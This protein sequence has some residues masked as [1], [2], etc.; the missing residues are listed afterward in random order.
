MPMRVSLFNANGLVGKANQIYSFFL[1]QDIDLMFIVETWL[2]PSNGPIFLDT[3][4]NITKFN[5]GIIK[6]GKR[7]TGGI[8]GFCKPSLKSFIRIIHEDPDSNFVLLKV[9]SQYVAVGY[10]APSFE[11]NLLLQA[12]DTCL[13]LVETD[14]DLIFMGDLN[15][16]V[17]ALVGDSYS[18]R[19]GKLLMSHLEGNSL[20]IIPPDVGRFSSFQHNGSGQPDLILAQGLIPRDITIHESNTLGG[21]DHRPIT[22]V[23]PLSLYNDKI[24]KRWNFSKVQSIDQQEQFRLLLE[25]S[26]DQ[27]MDN[28]LSTDNIEENWN[29]VKSW[30]QEAAE[31]AFGYF[32]FS[33]NRTPRGFN[34][35]ELKNLQTQIEEQET[36]LHQMHQFSDN[37]KVLASARKKLKDLQ[38]EY[39]TLTIK[40]RTSLFH[41]WADGMSDPRHADVLMKTIS[42]RKTRKSRNGCQL[43][44]ENMVEHS[45]YFLNTFGGLPPSGNIV[46][47]DQHSHIFNE[48]LTNFSYESI[49]SKISQLKLGKASGCD[50]ICAE[51]LI[52]G[53]TA[54]TEVLHVLFNQILTLKKIPDDW[55]KSLIVPVFKKGDS[56][57]IENYRPIALTSVPRRLFE[58]LI[59][60]KIHDYEHKLSEFQNGF[61]TNRSTIDHCYVLDYLMK[62]KK[63]KLITI[64][65]DFKAAFD[66]VDR[67]IL[68]Y[69]LANK[70]NFN[71]E[72]ITLLQELFDH[73]KSIILINGAKSDEISNLRGLLQGSS[74]SPVLFNFFIDDL[75]QELES[76]G[77]LINCTTKRINSLAFADDIA[78]V[79]DNPINMQILLQISQNWSNRN[80][81]RFAPKKCMV[82][83]EHS[84]PP[85]IFHLYDEELPIVLEAKYLGINFTHKGI[86]HHANVVAR[87]TVAQGVTKQLA[88]FGMNLNGISPLASKNLYKTF[89]R[90]I[91][92]YG[93]QL[94]VLYKVDIKAAQSVQNMA[95]RCMLSAQR[96]TSIASMHKLLQL[97]T[98]ELRNQIINSRY[99]GKL[100]NSE[101]ES[102]PAVAV[103]NYLKSSNKD[104]RSK[105]TKK[106]PHFILDDPILSKTD[107]KRIIQ[108]ELA[109][110]R[111]T[112]T[113]AG[114]LLYREKD[115]V[116][117]YLA[118]KSKTPRK[119]RI[120]LS[121]WNT[122]QVVRHDTCFT[123][124]GVATRKHALTCSGGNSIIQKLKQK[125]L[126]ENIKGYDTDYKYDPDINDLDNFLNATRNCQL[127][128]VTYEVLYNIIAKIYKH[129][130]NFRMQENGF[131]VANVSTGIG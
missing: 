33:S 46:L 97:E 48:C 95:L 74:L 64:L 67:S 8:L 6:G 130:L 29:L 68:W 30:I 126:E 25:N 39:K 110:Q 81:M 93:L 31:E 109:Q 43:D 86:N 42:C 116:R 118:L 36:I 18:D 32:E 83:Q 63:G 79:A 58:R 57:Q 34:S 3:F 37:H 1:N 26:V 44:P 38:T 115:Q 123:C 84:N 76:S 119:I 128:D 27:I 13:S 129:C 127:D 16:R 106:N 60:D 24:F 114:T 103:F 56:S 117:H 89:I 66:T 70:F 19:R 96:F 102:I 28:I 59:L 91:L 112:D 120:A 52:Y 98:M 69:R 71:L 80:G 111:E 75:L 101:D 94:E 61:R 53:K 49:L 10:F 4:I 113:V 12:I 5:F 9:K 92:E 78:L 90:P 125:L 108:E 99:L 73:N 124:G 17:G 62:Q 122:G 14:A 82:L 51:F 54:I 22:F 7:A 47:F 77:I 20:A 131:F 21:S 105:I 121:R 15:A 50:A 40:L 41:N 107:I 11:D 45:R 85:N 2:R 104:Y 87:S 72:L 23:L 35:L 65:L 55:K 88:E 100:C